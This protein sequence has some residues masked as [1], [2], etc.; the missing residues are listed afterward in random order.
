[1]PNAPSVEELKQFVCYEK[2][3]SVSKDPE[4]TAFKQA[5]RLHQAKWREMKG[6]PMGTHPYT[7]EPD[8]KSRRIGS[9]IESAFALSNGVNFL[10]DTIRNAVEHRISNKEKGQ[11]LGED[12]L[13]CNLLSSMPMCFNMFG[14]LHHNLDYATKAITSICPSEYL[15]SV[16]AVKFEWSPGR[17]DPKYLNNG[18]AFDVAFKT[19]TPDND[20]GI[21]GVETKYHEHCTY[22]KTLIKGEKLQRYRDVHERS[23]VF[24]SEALNNILGTELEQ[25]W[26]D[27]LLVLSMLQHESM[28]WH[29]GKFILVA[30]AKNSSYKRAAEKY[31][32]QLKDDFTFEYL[33][34]ESI[35]DQNIL[36]T[37]TSKLFRE[38]Y[39]W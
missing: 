20:Q 29:R 19:K 35:I 24:K 11:M 36:S 30:P 16:E 5:A 28:S 10:T 39:L 25:I 27:H 33:T 23:H 37:E 3:D 21:I 13:Y 22:S 6:Y 17:S 9:R 26:L 12:R 1:M 15:T 7:P 32:S 4:M 31:L 14:E 8:E 2:S 34:V 18:S 38:R